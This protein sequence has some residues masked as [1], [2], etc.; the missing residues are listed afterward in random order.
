MDACL[1]LFE[2]GAA[3]ES[4]RWIMPRDAWLLRRENL[5]PDTFEHSVGSSIR[6]FNASLGPR[7]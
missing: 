5:Q 6:Q 3:R 7:R 2:H 1:W 4:I